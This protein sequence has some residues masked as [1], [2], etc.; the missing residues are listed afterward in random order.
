MK[1]A[2]HAKTTKKGRKSLEE[3]LLRGRKVTDLLTE[4]GLLQTFLA[5]PN[6]QTWPILHHFSY[7]KGRE[8]GPET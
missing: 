5:Q 3:L 8:T 7:S 4:R 1:P 2:F 6:P